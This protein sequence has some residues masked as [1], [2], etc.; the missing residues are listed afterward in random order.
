M[1]NFLFV[2]SVYLSCF[3]SAVVFWVY[4]IVDVSLFVKKNLV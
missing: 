2:K 1:S 3:E 4:G